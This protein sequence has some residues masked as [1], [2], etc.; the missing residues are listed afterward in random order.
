MTETEPAAK[1]IK[2]KPI[3][4]PS[5]KMTLGLWSGLGFLVLVCLT[6]SADY[7]R[8]QATAMLSP[9]FGAPPAQTEQVTPDDL[10]VLQKNIQALEQQQTLFEESTEEYLEVLYAALEEYDQSISALEVGL[11]E[12]HVQLLE[13]PLPAEDGFAQDTQMQAIQELLSVFDTHLEDATKRIQTLETKAQQS[14]QNSVQGLAELEYLLRLDWKI[15]RLNRAVQAGGAFEAELNAVQET[16]RESDRAELAGALAVLASHAALAVGAQNKGAT[17]STP[18]EET[19]LNQIWGEIRGLVKVSKEQEQGFDAP[20][21]K[22]MMQINLW[23]K[24]RQG[25]F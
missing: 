7:W 14:A 12:M 24:A 13:S 9:V 8:P 17:E 15:S 18:A 16:L 6:I 20:V 3:P 22:A 19:I 23:L 10:L 11:E 1:P 25:Q 4:R 5:H 2:K 21:H